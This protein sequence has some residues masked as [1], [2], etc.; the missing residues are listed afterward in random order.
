MHCPINHCRQGRRCLNQASWSLPPILQDWLC[1]LHTICSP[2][3]AQCSGDKCLKISMLHPMLC[4][5]LVQV[6]F[7]VLGSAHPMLHSTNR[8]TST[9]DREFCCTQ[10]AG[11]L[12]GVA[13]NAALKLAKGVSH[14]HLDGHVQLEQ[15]LQACQ[16]G[17]QEGRTG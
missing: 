15:V 16:S 9:C 10:L 11:M 1:G 3:S 6:P 7:C 13:R 5:W 14:L 12:E 17:L 2:C 4:Y 8:S